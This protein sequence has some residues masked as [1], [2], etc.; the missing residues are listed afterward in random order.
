[1]T[2]GAILPVAI[3]HDKLYFLMGKE[4]ELEKSAKGWADF[5]GGGEAGETPFQTALREGSEELCG[6]LGGQDR[7]RQLLNPSYNF[8]YKTYHVFLFR[9]HYDPNL[10]LYYNQQHAFLWNKIDNQLLQKS[11]C[12]EKEQIRWFTEEELTTMRTEFRP[13]YQEVVDHMVKNHMTKIK[14]FMQLGK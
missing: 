2:G 3:Y 7:I 1:M 8:R 12:F 6:F 13:F 9:L 5:G 11:R 14:E 4:N 10:P